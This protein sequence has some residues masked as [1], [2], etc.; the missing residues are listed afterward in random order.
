MEMPQCPFARLGQHAYPACPGFAEAS[1]PAI[2]L[3]WSATAGVDDD[4]V[5]GGSTPRT[6]GDAVCA[7]LQTVRTL[8][9]SYRSACGHPGGLPLTAAGIVRR[10]YPRTTL[11]G[12]VMPYTR[13]E[14]PW[15]QQEG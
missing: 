13:Y 9:G 2:R 12:E 6:E 4:P 10:L 11:R 8:R 14:L 7:H 1:L 3:P 15:E 5:W